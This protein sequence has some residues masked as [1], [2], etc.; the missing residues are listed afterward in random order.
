MKK[1]KWGLRPF[2]IVL[3]VVPIGFVFISGDVF[4]LMKSILSNDKNVIGSGTL[5]IDIEILDRDSNEYVSSSKN[6]IPLFNYDRWEAGYTQ[7]VN[8]RIVNT[9]TL[10]LAYELEVVADGV[11]E[12]M[13]KNEPLLSDVIEVYYASDEVL[14]ATPADF[15]DAVAANKLKHMGSLTQ[16]LL[17]RTL[18]K[19][20]L[21]PMKNKTTY[22]DTSCDNVTFVFQMHDTVASKYQGLTV[23]DE[24][25][26][27]NLLATQ[28]THES[29]GFD[30]QYD[31]SK[32]ESLVFD[33]GQTHDVDQSL[34][35]TPDCTATDC[36]IADGEGTVVNIFGG[37]YNASNKG[38]AVWAKNGAVVNIYD[39]TFF[40]DGA[41]MTQVGAV[42]QVLIYAGEEGTINVYGGYF[43]AK[44]SD[45]A[46]LL[47]TKD[48]SG[49]IEVTGGTYKDWNPSNNVSDGADTNY[50]TN[51]T[52]VLPDTKGDASFYSVTSTA[53]AL[54]E[55][56]EGELVVLGSITLMTQ[57]IFRDENITEDTV[58]QGNGATLTLEVEP[59]PGFG[60]GGWAPNLSTVFSS[61][62]GSKTTVND[63]TFTGTGFFVSAGTYEVPARTTSQTEFN[64][65]NIVDMQ[66]I[67]FSAWTTAFN[68]CGIVTLNNCVIKGTTRSPLC[69]LYGVEPGP[70]ETEPRKYVVNDMVLS[71]GCKTTINGGEYGII[72]LDNS[73]N[74]TI[75]GATVDQISTEETGGSL[76]IGADSHIKLLKGVIKTNHSANTTRYKITIKDNAV[77][78]VLDLS[79]VHK[80]ANLDYITVADTATVHKIVD[81]TNE[82]DTI[83]EWKTWVKSSKA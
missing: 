18:L 38:C 37:N 54:R 13:L 6:D 4:A 45:G 43:A 29:D 80:N 3:L 65:V 40:C 22:D 60:N 23:G 31:I 68:T 50:L 46:W 9:G 71:N 57:P 10:S 11:L 66:V 63:L 25:F 53:N 20:V 76:I 62:N 1:Q 61:K 48:G 27:F 74:L 21:H 34:I 49:K 69:P 67:N 36:I 28:A 8:I 24:T 55:N 82:F 72:W 5:G 58:I 79:I 51:G 35:L 26:E 19:D 12:T 75:N 14:M 32:Q 78:D 30:N 42:P 41:D 83:D 39:G 17:S 81:G 59:F 33:D 2:L 47:D 70:D 16:I 44:A 73:A 52:I 64:N 7:P 77:V 15:D 56:K